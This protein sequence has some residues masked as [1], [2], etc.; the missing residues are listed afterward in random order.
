MK[1][2]GF[3]IVR[4]REQKG[5]LTGFVPSG[6]W[7]PLVRE[8]FSGAWQRNVEIK[9]AD[10]LAHPTAFRCIA[11]IASDIAKL[12]LRLME[13]RESGVLREA[14]RAAFS[15]VLRHPNRFQNPMQ[16]I[17]SWMLSKLIHG[18]AYVWKQRDARNVV[19]SLYVLDPLHTHPF[20]APDG[21]VFYQ[22]RADNLAGLGGDLMVPASE[23]IH[24]RFNTFYHP[25]MGLS[26]IMAAGL[27]ATQGLQI[28]QNQ[29]RFFVNESRPS[30]HLTAPGAIS[31]ET[32][33]RIK[34]TYEQLTT[35]ANVGRVVVTG[36]GLKAEPMTITPHDALVIEQLKWSSEIVAAVFGVPA[37]KVGVGAPPNFNNVAALN[38]QYYTQVLQIQ[39]ESIERLLDDGLALPNGLQ[40]QFDL[41]ALLRMDPMAKVEAAEK[42]VGAGIWS[43]DEARAKFD[44]EPVEGGS[45]PYL[46]QQNWSLAALARRDEGLMTVPEPGP[47]VAPEPVPAPGPAEE[48]AV[49]RIALTKA[50]DDA[51]RRHLR[52][53]A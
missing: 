25:L 42:A 10:V 39:I 22:I 23:M 33:R 38:D 4:Q 16:F 44:L 2:F 45:T 8:A 37:Y 53:A 11:L 47:V 7:F 36:D 19:V 52:S 14:E 26:P 12:R 32:A 40:T 51:K 18:N 28:Q 27:A 41:D 30:V 1:L 21:S 24:D 9:T 29:T 31:A 49:R 3:E 35:G 48:R 17:E 15:P 5:A 46:Q 13:R 20:V 6:G 43:P 34:E 50:V